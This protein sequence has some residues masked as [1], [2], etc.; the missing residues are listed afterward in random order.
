M[1]KP[2]IDIED[3]MAAVIMICKQK[4]TR[5]ESFLLKYL[6]FK[7][8]SCQSS[9][10]QYN[11]FS[12][13][14]DSHVSLSVKNPQ[15]DLTWQKGAKRQMANLERLIEE[16]VTFDDNAMPEQTLVLVEPYLKKPSFDPQIMERKSENK[17]C[18]SLCRWVKGVCRSVE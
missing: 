7:V 14:H 5:P 12:F 6:G 17:A 3:L 18:V 11:I 1:Q 4:N 2:V 13:Y 16:L 8:S 9:Y 15:A 10:V